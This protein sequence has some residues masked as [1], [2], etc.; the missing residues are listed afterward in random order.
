MKNNTPDTPVSPQLSK[1]IKKTKPSK[2][3][4]KSYYRYKKYA[5]KT[6][7]TTLKGENISKSTGYAGVTLNDTDG[8]YTAFIDRTFASGEKK[9]HYL[10]RHKLINSAIEA[11]NKFITLNSLQDTYTIQECK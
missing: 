9:R 10:G 6:P 11:R 1:V 5:P 7:T 4:S 3:R 2:E 8:L